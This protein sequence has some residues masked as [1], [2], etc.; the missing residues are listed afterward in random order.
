MV[1]KYHK[2]LCR[3]ANTWFSSLK[4]EEEE[5]DRSC[6]YFSRSLSLG[7][8]TRLLGYDIPGTDCIAVVNS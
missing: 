1:A 8:V 2:P 5:E 4:E 3:N 7:V 6:S